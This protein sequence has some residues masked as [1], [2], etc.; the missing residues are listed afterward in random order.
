MTTQVNIQKQDP[1]IEAY[2][3]G[4]LGD[5]QA[6][7]SGQIFGQN[8]QNL[9][10]QGLT[11][12]QIAQ[13]LTTD[14]DNPVTA[15]QVSGI[16]QD[17]LFSTPDYQI[18]G[19]TANQQDAI[20][21]AARGVG[22]YKPYIQGGL[23]AVQRGQA[24]AYDAMLGIG[25]T[26]G[27]AIGSSAL[28]TGLA[29][30]QQKFDPSG[31]SA[32]YDPYEQDVVQATLDD[33]RKDFQDRQAQAQAASDAQAVS[34]GAFS[35]QAGQMRRDAQNIQPLEDQYLKTAAQQIGAL[36]SAGFANAAQRAAQAFESQQQRQLQAST[37]I[38]TL[39]IQ[40]AGAQSNIGQQLAGM[41]VQQAG[42]GQLEQGL[43]SQDINALMGTGGMSQAQNQ[44]VLDAQR[45]SDLQKYQQPYQQLGF[46]SD[47][48]SG[49]PTSQAT[50]TMT[51]GTPAS[52]FQQA[53]GIGIAG[54]GAASSAKNLGLF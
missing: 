43:R 31:I 20:D 16:S 11:D 10:A 52:P 5:T 49:V 22:S 45:Q 41:G 50:T 51:M 33:L 13:A 46:L 14:P 28:G 47:V 6:L 24:G 34:R 27:Q 48:Y 2:R 8:V 53:A 23:D 18:A 37:G 12:D 36:R 42:L 54:L 30:A 29:G 19:L 35:S 39:G 15:G 9:R 4:L 17:A 40:G 21:L 38:G 7:V 25:G 1:E 26:Q 3:L 32:F 44:A